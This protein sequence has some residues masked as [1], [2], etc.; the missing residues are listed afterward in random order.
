MEIDFTT[1]LKGSTISRKVWMEEQLLSRNTLSTSLLVQAWRW[2]M[3]RLDTMQE[4]LSESR[5]LCGFS[6]RP[7]LENRKYLNYQYYYREPDMS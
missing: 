2:K 5:Y 6:Q 1:C 3:I 4:T 7:M